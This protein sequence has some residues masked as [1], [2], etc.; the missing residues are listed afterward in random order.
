VTS[1]VDKKSKMISERG[2]DDDTI[3]LLRK[4]MA[5]KRRKEERK[6]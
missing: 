1:P 6:K 4:G 5:M 3:A 2:Q